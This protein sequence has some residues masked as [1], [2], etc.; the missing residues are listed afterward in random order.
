MQSTKRCSNGPDASKDY[1]LCLGSVMG[2]HP[3]QAGARFQA[4]ISKEYKR[5]VLRKGRNGCPTR[6]SL[7]VG[8]GSTRWKLFIIILMK[9]G[10]AHGRRS[11]LERGIDTNETCR[12]TM[13]VGKLW[14]LH[15]MKSY[16]L[17]DEKDRSRPCIDSLPTRLSGI[18]L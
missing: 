1:S 4:I 14:Y 10:G 13:A 8:G 9:R 18:G 5:T 12:T 17:Q 11:W 16:L 7:C 15:G 2:P 6:S 3:F